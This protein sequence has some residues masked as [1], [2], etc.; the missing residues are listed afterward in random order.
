MDAGERGRDR[1]FAARQPQRAKVLPRRVVDAF[2]QMQQHARLLLEP[3]EEPFGALRVDIGDS[4]HR[5][6]QVHLVG[7]LHVPNDTTVVAAGAGIAEELDPLRLVV[8]PPTRH[9]HST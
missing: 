4:R 8:T 6:G 2:A 7:L 3:R 9:L 1:P 5:L